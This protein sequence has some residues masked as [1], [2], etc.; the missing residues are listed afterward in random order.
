MPLA[1]RLAVALGALAIG[2]GLSA[3]AIAS[4]IAGNVVYG[5]AKEMSTWAASGSEPGAEMVR[6]LAA[7]LDRVARKAPG[8]PNIE[9]LLGSLSLHRIERPRFLA[10][11][12]AHYRRAVEL[13]PSSPYSWANIAALDYRRGDTGP[14]FQAALR[15]AARL[16]PAEPEVQRTVADYG[17]ATWD[18]IAPPAR[19]AVENAITGAMKRDP[20]E[21][22]RLAERRGRLAVAC[23]HVGDA[24]RPADPRWQRLC[25][26]REDAR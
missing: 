18:E 6:W 13:R 3:A 11:A 10:E 7:D 24:T 15:N 23:R 1:G 12:R 16:G 2:A 8:D 17:L 22:L 25:A 20:A 4:G 21:V 9:E 19:A 26:S 14:E 5:V